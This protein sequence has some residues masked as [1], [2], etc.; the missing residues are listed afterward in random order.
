MLKFCAKGYTTKA[1]EHRVWVYYDNRRYILTKGPHDKKQ[2]IE[3]GWIQDMVDVFDI[4]ECA[5][6]YIEMIKV[7]K[8][9]EAVTE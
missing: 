4:A 9:S 6:R 8:K 2:E 5:H 3:I 7:P 1:K